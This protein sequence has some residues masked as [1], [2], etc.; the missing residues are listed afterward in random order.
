MKTVDD[1]E[2]IRRAYFIDNWSIREI[3]RRMRHGRAVIRKAIAQAEPEKYKLTRPRQARVLEPYKP[4]IEELLAKS[5]KNPR[6]QRYTAHKIYQLLQK[7]GYSGSEGSVHNYVSQVRKKR[8]QA[9]VFLPLEFDP[10]QDAQVDWG[11]VVVEIAGKRQTVQVF[12]LRLNYSKARFVMAFPFQKQEAFFEGHIQAFRFFGGVPRRLTYDNLK[13]AVFRVLEGHNRQE[14]AAFKAF[15]SY[16]LFESH[17]CTPAQGHEKGGVES[18]VGYSQRNFFVPIPQANNFEE[19]NASLRQ[20]CLDDMHRQVRG[21]TQPVLELWQAERTLFLPL[22]AT[23]YSACSTH[24]VKVNPYSQVV[25]ETNRYS[26]PTEYV[27]RQLAL[28]AYPFR[29]EILSLERIVAT[30]VRCFGREQ[31]VLDPLHYL[32]LLEQRPGAFEHA[33]PLRQWRKT[34][35]ADYER[36]LEAM[37]ERNPDGR[38][39]REFVAVLKLHQSYPGE[40]V[41][42]AVKQALELGTDHLDGV[43]LCLRQILGSEI[44][45]G[46]MDM[47]SYPDFAGVGNQPVNL[48][49]YNQLLSVR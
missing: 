28:R 18:D 3:G 4:K 30:H 41:A 11:E 47:E 48:E 40:A 33:L 46:S 2:A 24:M 13:T 37:R 35:S 15:R 6:K 23:D 36:L 38:G 29:V 39:V 5:E 43:Q 19:L 25:F 14:Q 44:L 1:Y 10:G 27:S 45:P 49:Q 7:E 22:G 9:P 32:E 17:Y 20:N 16:Y 21:Q 34:W 12:I 8:K 26:V 31:D 42:Q